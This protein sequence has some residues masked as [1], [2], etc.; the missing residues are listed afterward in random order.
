VVDAQVVPDRTSQYVAAS[1]HPS[2][3]EI[4]HIR[5]EILSMEQ[6]LI[7]VKLKMKALRKS[8]T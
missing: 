3:K 8:I 1:K 4:H 7:D 5:E 6:Q 2:K